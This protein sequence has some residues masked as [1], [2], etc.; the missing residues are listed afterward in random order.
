MIIKK[1][2][3]MISFLRTTL[4]PELLKNH[5][6]T[7]LLIWILFIFVLPAPIGLLSF[8]FTG[9]GTIIDL[10]LSERSALLMDALLSIMFFLQHSTLVRP[11]I[12]NTLAKF[13]P[14]EYY[15]AFYGIT[16]GIFLLPVLIFW[17]KSPALIYRAD[18]V[19]HWFLHGLF[20]ICLA[21]FFWG[22]SSLSSIDMLGAKRLMRY[23][24]NRPEKPQ[25]I[26]AKGPYRWVRHPLYLFLI[27]LIWSCPVLYFD[28][29]LFNIMWTVWIVIATYMEDRDLHREFGRQYSEYSSRVPMLIP[30]R[31]PRSISSW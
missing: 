30:C 4:N 28:R 5:P 14:E 15:S 23:I 10:H 6:K 29:L 1:E 8:L 21:G 31:M 24:S 22:G 13:I 26:A 7:V 25:Q 12:K 19:M 11:G 9:S 3:R 17:Q 2:H 16:S 27:V 20:F 18:G